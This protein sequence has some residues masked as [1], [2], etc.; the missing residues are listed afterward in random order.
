MV[1]PL[2]QTVYVQF[3]RR[4]LASNNGTVCRNSA[5]GPRLVIDDRGY[6]CAARSLAATGCCE[7]RLSM[8]FYFPSSA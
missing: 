4:K 1:P 7:A 3:P 2:D 8:G 5:Q 6:V